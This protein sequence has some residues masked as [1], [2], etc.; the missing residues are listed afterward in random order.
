MRSLGVLLFYW[1]RERGLS[2][3]SPL[4]LASTRALASGACD[5]MYVGKQLSGT[6]VGLHEYLHA[7][8]QV[9][10][11]LVGLAA[12]CEW[13]WGFGWGRP[14]SGPAVASGKGLAGGL[15]GFPR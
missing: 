14:G 11:Q 8:T 6:A 1:G 10:A 3:P 7:A 5:A 13:R 12:A 2:Y 9:P 4:L 15:V